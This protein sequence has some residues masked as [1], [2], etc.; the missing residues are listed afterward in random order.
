MYKVEVACLCRSHVQERACTQAVYDHV[1][2]WGPSQRCC[3]SN[4]GAMHILLHH[5][6]MPMRYWTHFAVVYATIFAEPHESWSGN[7]RN[8]SLVV[9][10]WRAPWLAVLLHSPA[11]GNGALL[12]AGLLDLQAVALE[13]G[14]QHVVQAHLH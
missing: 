5:S 7:S 11:G 9:P 2:P 3:L 12:Q 10:V 1:L 8:S 13:P 14:V 6:N 4:K